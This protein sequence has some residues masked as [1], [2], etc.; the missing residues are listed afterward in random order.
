MCSLST[1]AESKCA[2]ETVH[3][4]NKKTR[5]RDLNQYQVE[6]Q[7]LGTKCSLSLICQPERTF[8][9]G[10]TRSDPV[11]YSGGVIVDDFNWSSY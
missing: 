7:W 10:L 5:C 3:L 2:A 11:H 4:Q 6:L 8:T 1:Q 9:D